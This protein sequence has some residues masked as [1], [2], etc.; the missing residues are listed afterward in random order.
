[1]TQLGIPKSDLRDL[2]CFN[3]LCLLLFLPKLKIVI[4]LPFDSINDLVKCHPFTILNLRFDVILIIFKLF[5]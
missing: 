4:T 1:V 5:K 3:V 2:L